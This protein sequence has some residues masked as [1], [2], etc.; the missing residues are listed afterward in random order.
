LSH[1]VTI[2]TE[3][4]DPIAVAAACRRLGLAGPVHGTAALFSGESTGLLVKLPGWV[5]P[6]VVHPETG[7]VEF[8]NYNGAWGDRRRLDRFLQVYAVEKARLEARKKGYSVDE[9]TLADG[10]VRLTVTVAIGGG[11]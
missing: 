4:R 5:Y 7:R 11:A 8:D 9:R 2:E 3:V 1:I 6:A 10:S